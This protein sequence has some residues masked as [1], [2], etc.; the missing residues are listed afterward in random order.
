MGVNNVVT[1][2][3]LRGTDMI[4]LFRQQYKLTA[5]QYV[6][7]RRLRRRSAS[8]KRLKKIQA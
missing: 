5:V 4:E 1:S 6:V 3:A 2:C 7:Q 8:H